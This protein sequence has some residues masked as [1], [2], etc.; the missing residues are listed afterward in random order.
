MISS[1][2]N[3]TYG[4]W[5]L[6]VAVW[7]PGYF[8]QNKVARVPAPAAQIATS[9]LIAV[10]FFMLL[11]RKSPDFLKVQITPR[12]IWLGLL[13]DTLCVASVVLAICARVR[14]GANWSGTVAV[15]RE[16]HELV[17]SGPY[18]IVR[19]P[20]YTGLL[21]AML[22]TAFTIGTIASYLAVLLALV[23]FLARI[24]VEEKLMTSQFPDLYPLYK[25]RT[26]ALVPFLW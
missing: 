18:R 22:G 6:L 1:F 4:A 14:L 3:V 26:R 23:G 2:T 10:A 9:L 20:I 13:G 17:Q 5:A 25:Q 7:V 16:G 24:R 21:F 19:H 11:S 12:Q 15:V 8:R